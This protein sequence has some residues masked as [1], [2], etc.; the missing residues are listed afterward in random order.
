MSGSVTVIGLGPGDPR[1]LTPAAQA[2]LDAAQD[3]IG[4]FP[5][6][7]RVPERPGL[8]RHASDNRVEVDRA[9]HALALAAAGRR[10]AVVSGGDPGVFAMAA[11][12]FEALEAGDPAWRALS[13]TVEPGITAMLAAAARI[14]APLGGDFCALSLSDNLKPWEVITARLNAV[15]AADLV[16]A[17][18][19]PISRA[20]PWQ[21]GVALGLAAEHRAPE[22]PVILARAVGRPDEAIRIL[23]LAQAR[24]AEADMATLVMI[25]AS[26]TR[27]IPREGQAPFVYTPRSVAR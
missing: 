19:N 14:G 10:V 4:Y 25:G 3:L 26:A 16:I 18:Y 11:A 24:A 13:I 21:L 8:T 20:R 5:Y 6:V 2:A 15:L 17:L 23:T 27:L 12:L 7:A 22:T 1:Y 9:R